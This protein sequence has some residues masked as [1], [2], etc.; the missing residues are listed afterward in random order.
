MG[1]LDN[2]IQ[3]IF[4]ITNI[5]TQ[6]ADSVSFE[7][8]SERYRNI[9]M[10]QTSNLTMQLSITK[11]ITNPINISI[12]EAKEEANE[13]VDRLILIPNHNITSLKYLGFKDGD[14]NIRKQR[15]KSNA[16]SILVGLI[17]D[18]KNYYN[19]PENIR[20][21][22]KKDNIGILRIYRTALSI[23]DN[24]S[25]YLIF[26]GLLLILKGESQ[27]K[28]D[29]FIKQEIP[30]IQIVIGKHSNETIITKI[31]NMIAHPSNELNM[32]QLNEYIDNYL[33][34]LKNIVLKE[35]RN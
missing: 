16:K 32:H 27:K 17:S 9:T 7:S 20:L 11:R 24:I 29:N 1:N 3:H 6:I 13:L 33:D 25:Q 26:Y 21:L 12:N 5:G 19:K 2:M 15:E 4:E 28:V 22:D 30:D 8:I 10:T 14:E 31:R 35:L 34:T 23:N 18:P